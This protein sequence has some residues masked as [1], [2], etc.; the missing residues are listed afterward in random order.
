M[1]EGLIPKVEVPGTGIQ[2]SRLVQG[3]VP[4]SRDEEERSFAVLDAFW[5]SGGNA[6]DLA[7]IYRGGQC[8]E[9]VG[10]WVRSR[11]VE[12]EAVLYTKGCHPLPE[13]RVSS[14]YIREDLE[15]ELSRL[16]LDS[17]AFFGFHRDDL[18]VEVEPLV[19]E[20]GRLRD[21]GKVNAWGA[22]NWT[23]ERLKEFNRAAERLGLPGFAFNNPNLSLGLV[24]EPMWEGCHTLTE[25]EE[26]WHL[27]SGFPLWSWSSTGGGWFAFVENEDMTRV[28]D[29][30]TNQ[31]RRERAAALGSRFG[32]SAV[33]AALT[34]VLGRPFPVWAIV[35]CQTAD[36]IRGLAEV[37]SVEWPTAEVESL[38]VVV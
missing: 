30:P 36:Q 2:V 34:W 8:T 25:A 12:G 10:D 6:I 13:S 22:S 32:M 27:E 15:T 26:A 17:V 37:F 35:G 23:V 33:Q 4:F 24:N 28:W 7:S 3:S 16:K 9:V 21:E 38:R 19:E 1:S 11:G 18:S 29:N 14:R 20:L 31:S 5:E